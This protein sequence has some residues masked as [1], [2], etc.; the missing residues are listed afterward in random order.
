MK[1]THRRFL[2]ITVER[3]IVGKWE[4][5]RRD[6]PLQDIY[7]EIITLKAYYGS[8]ISANKTSDQVQ[9]QYDKVTPKAAQT[10]VLT[11]VTC[12]ALLDKS[13]AS[14]WSTMECC[15]R[16]RPRVVER[17]IRRAERKRRLS[18][19]ERSRRSTNFACMDEAFLVRIC[20]VWNR[21]SSI[22]PN[23]WK[24]FNTPTL[25]C[26]C[27]KPFC[28]AQPAKHA[29]NMSEDK[30]VSYTLISNGNLRRQP[31]THGRDWQKEGH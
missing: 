13:V 31:T 17:I 8:L 26:P 25:T 12:C 10:L 9:R 7:Q 2:A 5:V 4:A 23:A 21:Y 16:K 28:A 14:D 20:T 18:H 3:F 19:E 6:T 29:L 30:V 24:V 15:A 1:K 22:G 11:L 27:P